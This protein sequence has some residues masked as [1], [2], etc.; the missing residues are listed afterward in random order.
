MGR[1]FISLILSAALAESL[2]Q[3]RRMFANM[4]WPCADR[5]GRLVLAPALQPLEVLALRVVEIVY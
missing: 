1:D 5:G 2:G 4:N 3:G